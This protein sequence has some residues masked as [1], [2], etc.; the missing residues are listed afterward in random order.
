MS[1]VEPPPRDEDTPVLEEPL[2]PV[3]PIVV[4]PGNPLK[5]VCEVCRRPVVE[6]PGGWC[7]WAPQIDRPGS[8]DFHAAVLAVEEPVEWGWLGMKGPGLV[9]TSRGGHGLRNAA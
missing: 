9:S 4:P 6:L 1:L 5:D 3:I 2:A 7:H 8:P